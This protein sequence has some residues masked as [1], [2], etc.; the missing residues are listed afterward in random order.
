VSAQ[1]NSGIL[2]GK[3]TYRSFLNDPD[4]A[5]QFN[6]LEFGRGTIEIT[7]A[8]MNELKGT[9]GGPG[10]Q[11]QLKGSITYGN[12][13][14]VRFQGKG[15]ISGQEWV[16]DYIGYVVRPWPNGV[17]QRMAM[18]GSIVRTI[19]HSSGSGGTSPAGVVCSWIAVRQDDATS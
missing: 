17:N 4:L 14:T 19:P 1:P 5:T 15:V 6:D 18:V 16:Y 3:W 2:V 8:P 11:L 7:A 12:P 13:F 10:W 9:I